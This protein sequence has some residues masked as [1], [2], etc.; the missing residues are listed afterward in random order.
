MH[1]PRFE[2]YVALGDSSTEGLDDPDGQGGYRGWANRLA[3][4]I[5]AAQGSLLYANLGVRGLRTRQIRDRQLEPARAMRP[6]LA[7]L[8]TGTNDAVSRGFNPATVVEDLAFMQRT[9]IAGG[10]TV[11]SFT[12]PELSN[13][14]PFGRWLSP[15]VHGLNDAIRR[16]CAGTGAILVDFAAYPVASDARLWSEDR[17]HANALGHALISHALAH[18]I[19]VPGADDSWRRPFGDDAVQRPGESPAR[20]VVRHLIPWAWRH[21]RG[22]SSGDGRIAKRPHLVAMQVE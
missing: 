3:E 22:R 16:A 8:F 2:R 11:V 19:G 6:D 9:L 18:A 5:A 1:G 10:A 20:W 4:R 7:T 15:R 13:V 21:A 17:F 14:L 12:L